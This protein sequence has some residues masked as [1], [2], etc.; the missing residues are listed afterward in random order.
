MMNK[1]RLKIFFIILIL[2][3]IIAGWMALLN[4]VC[5]EKCFSNKNPLILSVA[6]YN[7]G[8]MNAMVQLTHRVYMQPFNLVSLLIFTCAI[9]H[10]FF[11]RQFSSLSQKLR[12][13]NIKRKG[14]CDEIFS[15]EILHFLG[16]VEVVFGLWVIPLFFSLIYVYGWKTAVHYMDGLHEVEPVFVV[17]I[18]ALAS[19]APIIKFAEYVMQLVA[20]VGKDSVTAWWWVILTLGPIAGSLITEPAAMTISAFLLTRKFY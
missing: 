20:K 18:M 7:D 1:R 11:C 8:Q 3:V 16:E 15:V 5:G 14:D 13:R 12:E 10:T 19:T 2:G 6:D 9:L 4:L 17:V